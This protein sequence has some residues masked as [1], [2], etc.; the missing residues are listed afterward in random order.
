MPLVIEGGRIP[1][2][3]ERRMSACARGFKETRAR[4]KDSITIALINNMPDPALEDTEMQFFELLESA[5]GDVTVRVRLLSL[6]GIARSERG[7]QRL[8]DFYN[9]VEELWN[10]RIDAIIMTGTEPHRPQLSDEPYWPALVQLLSWAEQN[11]ISTVLSCL[12][13]HAGVLYS[14]GIVRQPLNEKRCGV[15]NFEKTSDHALTRNTAPFI[16]FPH[17][18]WNELNEDTLTAC[19][20]RVLTRSAQAGVDLFVKKKGRSLFLHFQG[21][22]EYGVRTLLKEYRRD[23][24]RFLRHERET[25]PTMPYGYFDATAAEAFARFRERALA[26]RNE[27]ILLLFPGAAAAGIEKSWQAPA[28]S[29]YGNWL[30]YVVSGKVY[31]SGMKTRSEVVIGHARREQVATS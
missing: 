10:A 31:R 6:P 14:D 18:R 13:A 12:A 20:Y 28:V 2:L 19:D 17:S 24:R 29:I 21:H 1:P 8:S 23:I 9:D 27:D 22:P 25:Y 30:Q 5:A 4:R 3:W 7:K 26:H 11:T 16:P 15:F